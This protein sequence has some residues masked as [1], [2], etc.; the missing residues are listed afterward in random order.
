MQW[1]VQNYLTRGFWRDEAWTA[2]ISALPVVD[3]IRITGE[4]FHPPFYYLLVHGFVGLFGNSE[5]IRLI[6]VVFWLLTPWPVYFLMRKTAGKTV[7]LV[8]AIL[9][10][11]SPVLFIYAFEARSYALLAFLS[12]LSSLCFWKSMATKKSFWLLAY[13]ITAVAGMYTHYYMWFII[14]AHGVAW[15]L[16]YRQRF[17]HYV[18]AFGGLLL[19]QLPWVP[20]LVSQV[21][22]VKQNYWIGQIDWWTHWKWFVIIMGGDN[23]Q[24]QRMFVVWVWL[25]WL[26]VSPILMRWRY[27]RWPKAYVYLWLWFLVPVLLPTLLSLT[28][29]PVFFYRYLIFSSI[30]VLLIG[31]WGLAAIRKWFVCGAA[32]FSL[33]F[34]ISINGLNFFRFPYSIRERLDTVFADPKKAQMLVT[35]LLPFPEVAYYNHNRLPIRITPE[36]MRQ[37]YGKA[38]LD[39]YVRMNLVT[40]GEAP[41]DLSYWLVTYEFAEYHEDKGGND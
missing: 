23:D 17:W 10:L 32:A 12:A 26:V 29:R 36:N 20:T 40:I 27:K 18:A 31:V 4:D 28:F 8:G 7:A 9:T 24:P 15:L 13:S 22:S 33:A 3:I 34:Y 19:A 6:S 14:A 5:F 11:A 2:L 41:N 21:S 16:L 39:A 38:L 25:F 37:D 30:P 1:L 35:L